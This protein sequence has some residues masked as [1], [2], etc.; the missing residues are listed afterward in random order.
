MRGGVFPHDIQPDLGPVAD[1]VG[2]GLVE[3]LDADV[4][5][6]APEEVEAA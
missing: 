3:D 5:R 2:W 4:G 1:F 6:V